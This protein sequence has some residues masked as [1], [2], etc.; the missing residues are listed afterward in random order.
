[1][2]F[3]TNAAPKNVVIHRDSQRAFLVDFAECGFRED[4]PETSRA[5]AGSGESHGGLGGLEEEEEEPD[6]PEAEYWQWAENENNPGAI[7]LAMMRDLP[8]VEMDVR[9]PNYEKIQE[10]VKRARL[11]HGGKGG[12]GLDG[13]VRESDPSHNCYGREFGI[14]EM[15]WVPTVVRH[16][17]DSCGGPRRGALM[18]GYRVPELGPVGPGF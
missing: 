4:S 14:E 18:D 10:N 7:A 13:A 6:N 16:Y 15:G 12:D 9:Y 17:V 5:D 3:Y 1:V 2:S 8:G 11:E